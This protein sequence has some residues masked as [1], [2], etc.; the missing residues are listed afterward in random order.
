MRTRP[1][2]TSGSSVTDR[3]SSSAQR[4]RSAA[5]PARAELELLQLGQVQGRDD[6]AA[7]RGVPDLPVVHADQDAVA[8]HPHVALDGVRADRGG[9]AVGRQGVLGGLRGR[10]AVGDDLGPVNGVGGAERAARG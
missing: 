9:L 6:A 8:G 4:L 1:F 3:I 5:G 2:S 10:A 7:V